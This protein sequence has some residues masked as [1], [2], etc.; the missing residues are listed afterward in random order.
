MTC[1]RAVTTLVSREVKPR[2][3]A[4]SRHLI[5]TMVTPALRQRRIEATSTNT[6]GHVPWH[7][8]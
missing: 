7:T 5:R 3:L 1:D 4:D 8:R 6:A 2:R